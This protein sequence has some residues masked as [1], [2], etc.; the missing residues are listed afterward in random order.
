MS[1]KNIG[2]SFDEFLNEEGIL[3]D[4]QSIAASRVIAWQL[5]Q[6]MKEKHISKNKMAKLMN[7]SR[8]QVDRLL[9]PDNN[10]IQLSTLQ[11]AATIVGR[12][13]VVE[14]QPA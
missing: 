8:T 14:L 13:L 9:D 3:E 12:R 10:S 4:A 11:R 1:K 2:S 6:A 5:E 7:T